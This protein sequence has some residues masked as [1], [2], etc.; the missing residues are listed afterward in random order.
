MRIARSESAEKHA[1]RIRSA[2]TIGVLQEQEL[3]TLSNV[4][5]AVAQ[6]HRRRDVQPVREDGRALRDTVAIGILQHDD[7]VVRNIP[8]KDMRIR[9]RDGHVRAAGRVPANRNRIG[10]AVSL[11]REEIDLQAVRHAERSKLRLD[12]RVRMAEEHFRLGALMPRVL[13]TVGYGPD[14]LLRLFDQADKLQPLLAKGEIAVARPGETPRRVIA[15]EQ[16]PVR[17]T[18]V[19]EPQALLLDDCRVKRGQPVPRRG[20]EAKLRRDRL[21]DVL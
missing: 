17:G 8:G 18:P 7:L 13:A 1:S 3:T 14:A 9:R 16:L 21:R 12:V 4:D 6:F 19:V 15:V 20:L 5:P 11:R 10:Q 2:I